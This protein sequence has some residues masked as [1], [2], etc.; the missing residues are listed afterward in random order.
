MFC[1]ECEQPCEVI[2]VDFGIGPH[3][4]WGCSGYH[5]DLCAVSDCCEADVLREKGVIYT[6]V[7]ISDLG[8]NRWR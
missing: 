5:A 3:E 4:F 8:I 6:I 1:A 2:T 7:T